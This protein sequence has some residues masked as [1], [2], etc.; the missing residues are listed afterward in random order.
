MSE[1][2]PLP[3]HIRT[4]CISCMSIIFIFYFYYY[5]LDQGNDPSKSLEERSGS[6]EIFLYPSPYFPTVIA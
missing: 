6:L 5:M 1:P 3:M 2:L 4:Y